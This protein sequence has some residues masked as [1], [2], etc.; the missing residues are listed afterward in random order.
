MTYLSVALIIPDLEQESSV[1]EAKFPCSPFKGFSRQA[2]GA[3]GFFDLRA[4]RIG[5]V[6][7]K[8]LLIPLLAG[9]GGPFQKMGEA[10]RAAGDLFAKRTQFS[11]ASSA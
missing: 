2:I 9:E 8:T 7:E 11:A 3:E 4:A 1:H 10:V 5:Q 6:Q